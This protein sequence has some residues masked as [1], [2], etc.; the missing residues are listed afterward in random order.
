MDVLALIHGDNVRPGSFGQ[1]VRRRGDRL[2]EWSLALGPLPRDDHDALRAETAA[3][4]GDWQ[5]LGAR[6]DGAFLDYAAGRSSRLDHSC[7]EPA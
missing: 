3:K 7:H 2:T 4:I 5:A 1:V 6:L